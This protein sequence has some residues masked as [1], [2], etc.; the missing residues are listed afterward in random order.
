MK[1]QCKKNRSTQ[2]CFNAWL[3]QANVTWRRNLKFLTELRADLLNSSP[4]MNPPKLLDLVVCVGPADA[5]KPANSKNSRPR[6]SEGIKDSEHR[7]PDTPF[8][9]VK[10]KI[11][12]KTASF[13]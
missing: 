12:P 4:G 2:I 3:T 11:I 1:Q 5:E 13:P 9:N 10:N 6:S 8:R 7:P